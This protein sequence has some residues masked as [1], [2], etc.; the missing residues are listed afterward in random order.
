MDKSLRVLHVEDSERDVALLT[1]HLSHAGYELISER[2]DTPAAMKAALDGKE[3]DVILCDYSMPQFNALAAV[4]LLKE[5]ELDIPLIIISGTVGEAVAVEAMRAGAQDYLMKDNLLRLAP[6]IERE[7]QEAENLRARRQAEAAL[8]DSEAELRALFAAMSDVIVVIDV[9]GRQ[10]KVAPTNPPYVH[11]LAAERIGKTLHEIFPKESADLFLRYIRSSL[12]EGRMQQL[13]YTLEIEGQERQFEGTV[14]P[15]SQD[16]VVWIARDITQRKQAEAE[17]AELTA[18]VEVQRQR[19]NNIVATVPGMVWE[20]WGEP[21]SATQQIDFVSDYVE[22]LVGYSVNDWLSTPNFWLSIVHPEDREQAAREAANAFASLSNGTSEFRWIAKDGRHVWVESNFMVITNSEGRPVGVRGVTTDISER[23]R[24]E[25]ALRESEERYKGLIDSAFD[26]VVIMK[27]GIIRSANRAY[28]E[29]FGYTVAELIGMD[30]LKLT[31]E[32]DFVRAQMQANEPRYETSGLKKDG[33]LI[34]IEVSAK[35]CLYQGQTARLSAVRDITERKH[36]EEA[37]RESEERYRDFVEN[38]RDIIYSHDLEGHYTSTNRAGEKLLGYTREES[39]KLNLAQIVAPEY[40]DKARRMIQGK[41]DGEQETVYDLELI[42][43][44]GHRLAVEVNTRLVFEDDVPVGVQGIARDITERK[45]VEAM[46]IRRGAQLALRGD[47]NSALAESNIP[48]RQILA[49]SA[50]AIVQHLGAAFAR[51]WTLNRDEDMLELQASAGIYTHLDGPHARV[52]VG[53]FKIG[54]IAATRVP[55]ISNDVQSDPQVGNKDWARREGMIAFAGYPLIVEDRLVGV[56]AMFARKTLADDTL[57]SLASVADI[58]S[59]GIERKRVEEALQAS[60]EQLRQS[61]K[62]EAVGQLAGG[63]AHDFNNLLTVITGY[64]DLTLKKLAQGD[65]ARGN[66]EEI[67]KAGERAASLTRQLLAFSRKQVLQPKVLNLNAIVS[68]VDKMLRR[69]IGEDIDLLTILEP[70][71]GKINA[72]P[73]QIEQVVLNMVVNARDAMPLGGKITI[74]TSNVYLDNEYGRSHTAIRP[75]NYV[76]LAFSDTGTGMDAAT[77][78]HIF[79]PFFTTKGQGKG[80]GL[81]LS[82]VYGIVKQSEGNV[83]VYSEVGQGT[84]FKVYLPRVDDAAPIETDSETAVN[85]KRG[86]ETVLLAEDEEPVRRLTKTIL[87][88]NGYQVLEA[89]SGAQA[90]SIYKDHAGPVNL[91]V[92]DVV[93]PRMGGRELA[94]SLKTLSPK[95]KVLYVSGYTDDAIVRHGLLDQKMAFLQKPFTPDALL[96]KVREVL[97]GTLGE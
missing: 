48:L 66:V 93:M 88:S 13:E 61:Q 76:M 6:T 63:V 37:L 14:S 83:W 2:V 40:V 86:R 59:Q 28:G 46:Q 10:L 26:G 8:R 54:H 89:M 79:E 30:V 52:A 55:H 43:K 17:K 75:G 47:I 36:A 33:T 39:L 21:S 64:S 67:K 70:G 96:R 5:A 9:E 84:T 97:D 19:L 92:T 35:V 62:L 72:D 65:P 16:S 24:A 87:E 29:M 31:A 11:T 94:E 69:L 20:A 77:Q 95:I 4:K 38:A 34:K 27:D 22:T 91:I 18:R 68:D 41:L 42:A 74:E 60:E 50:E 56:V 1:R 32:P 7:L 90:L 25:E 53:A 80:T 12:T 45:R 73:G 44:D 57:D 49:H 81:G 15:I 71:L 82:T 78:A 51:I 23:K 58:I 3:W 85:M